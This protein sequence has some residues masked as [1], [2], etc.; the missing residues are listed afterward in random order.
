MFP[1]PTSD[2]IAFYAEHGWI[3]V[4]DAIPQATLD[5]IEGYCDQ[6]IDRKEE[7]AFDWAWAEGESRDA[8]SFRIIQSK[9]EFVW[10]EVDAQPYRQWLVEFASGLMERPMAFWYDQFLAKP[11]GRSVPTYWHQDEGY[12]GR[13]LLNKGITCWIPLHDVDASNGCMHF[14]D[15]GHR[16]GIIE[17]C[18]VTGVQSDL[19]TCAV[20]EAR[21]VVAPLK[22]G[23]V[24][25]HHSA[26]PHMTTANVSSRYRKAISNHIQ[27]A[28]SKGEGDH[29][30][31]KLSV[32]QFSGERNVPAN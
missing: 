23:D 27:A 11:P 28:D 13:N 8:R 30:S 5:E 25:F 19:L 17:H 32:N 26:M 24:T 4:K 20:D 22:R 16:D 29:Y 9:P 14:I 15:R 2:Q 6:L 10:P 3:I 1:K 31:W 21:L 7:I 12:W 18:H